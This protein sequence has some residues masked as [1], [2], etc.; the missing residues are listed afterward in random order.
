MV[1][2][3]PMMSGDCDVDGSSVTF[4]GF[5]VWG[6]KCFDEVDE[7]VEVDEVY[8]VDEVDEVDKVD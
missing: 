1:I 3:D 2:I 6:E 7:V 5:N 8:E 4:S